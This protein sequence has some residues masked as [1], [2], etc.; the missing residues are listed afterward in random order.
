MHQLVNSV[1]AISVH[2]FKVEGFVSPYYVWT[3]DGKCDLEEGFGSSVLR[4]SDLTWANAGE[5]KC[6]VTDAL[7]T[8]TMARTFNVQ[9]PG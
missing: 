7:T 2:A 4:R 1:I 5:Y 6:T 8:Q 9:L 3:K